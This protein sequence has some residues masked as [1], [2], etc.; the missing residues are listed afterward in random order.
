M[1][2]RAVRRL[3]EGTEATQAHSS[4]FAIQ[5][6]AP[7]GFLRRDILWDLPELLFPCGACDGRGQYVGLLER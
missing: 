5:T 2:V 4:F 3:L 7:T 1:P 6:L